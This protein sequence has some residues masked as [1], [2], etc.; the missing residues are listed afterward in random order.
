MLIFC[1][2]A[3]RIGKRLNLY[4]FCVGLT[5]LGTGACVLYGILLTDYLE[6]SSS[7]ERLERELAE[8]SSGFRAD[9]KKAA[10]LKLELVTLEKKKNQLVSIEKRLLE[11][12]SSL[13]EKQKNESLLDGTITQRNQELQEKQKTLA[14]LNERASVLE[15]KLE[16][17]ATRE[18]Q[19]KC[20]YEKLNA[21]NTALGE[22]LKRKEDKLQ[23][24]QTVIE[25]AEKQ[26][27][28]MQAQVNQLQQSLSEVQGSLSAYQQDE[29]Q[30]GEQMKI[31][32]AER[33][34]VQRHLVELQNKIDELTNSRANTRRLEMERRLALLQEG[35]QTTEAELKQKA[36]EVKAASDELAD[37]VRRKEVLKVECENLESRKINEQDQLNA[38]KEKYDVLVQKQHDIEEAITQKNNI[39][40]SSENNVDNL[41]ERKTRLQAECEEL[42]KAI[43]RERDELNKLRKDLKEKEE[44]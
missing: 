25:E 31:L 4:I 29:N 43:I 20:E 2:I 10:A 19:A 36:A 34:T 6:W 5:F 14:S 8:L 11:L 18:A 41:E 16:S 37:C 38:L 9:S 7:R 39:L 30:L 21:V 3:E 28:L 13:A 42:E 26:K 22:D 23:R 15:E 40:K 12:Q 24:L 44:Q 1:R 35:I 27:Q 33:D 17:L 32:R